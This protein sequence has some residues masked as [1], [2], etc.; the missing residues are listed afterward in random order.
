MLQRSTAILN[1]A[2]SV[3][4]KNMTYNFLTTKRVLFIKYFFND[5]TNWMEQ[6]IRIRV[7]IA[8][9]ETF[10]SLKALNLL[11]KMSN[12]VA[13]CFDKKNTIFWFSIQSSTLNTTENQILEFEKCKHLATQSA[14]FTKFGCLGSRIFYHLI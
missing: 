13:K 1:I 7:R 8:N 4:N 14:D 5:V 10:K 2:E 12:G 3:S 11:I 9:I 6:G